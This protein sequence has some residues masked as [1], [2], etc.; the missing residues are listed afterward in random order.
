MQR[1]LLKTM[2]IFAVVSLFVACSNKTKTIV[3]TPPVTQQHTP[4]SDKAPRKG[5][6]NKEGRPDFAE[7]LRK[8]DNNQD[9]KLAK[10][11]VNGPLQQ[12]F[13]QIDSNQD[14]YLTAEEFDKAPPPPHR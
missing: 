1:N 14:G 7:L 8:M 9:G 12:H 5:Q 4:L 10:S 13:A 6:A 2:I 3:A 11:E